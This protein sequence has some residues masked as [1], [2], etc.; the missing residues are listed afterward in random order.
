MRKKTFLLFLIG[1]VTVGLIGYFIAQP[2]IQAQDSAGGGDEAITG[3]IFYDGIDC[4]YGVG[5]RVLVYKWT[6]GGLAYVTYGE[7]TH[8]GAGYKWLVTPD[9]IDNQT[10]YYKLFPD[11]AHTGGVSPE[12]RD[13]VYWHP[14]TTVYQQHFTAVTCDHP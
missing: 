4:E 14:G 2:V 3:S 7:V 5:D 1:F 13:S 6:A 8:F 11:L 9:D 12:S 10:G